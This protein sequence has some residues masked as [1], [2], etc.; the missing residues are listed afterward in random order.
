MAFVPQLG[1]SRQLARAQAA[2]MRLAAERGDQ[3]ARLIALE[4]GLALARIVSGMGPLL[5]WLTGTAIEGLILSELLNGL[6]LYPV[7]DD[8]WLVAADAII[9][10]ELIDLAPTPASLFTNKHLEHL[11][12]IQRSF[13]EGGR[14]VPQAH[15]NNHYAYDPSQAPGHLTPFGD[16]AWSNI[17]GRVYLSQGPV[18]AWFD[19]ART[20]A[21]EAATATGQ[22]ALTAEAEL[23]DHL[24]SADWRNPIGEAMLDYGQVVDIARR[25]QIQIAGTRVVLAIE[26]YRL[27]NDGCTPQSLDDLGDLLPEHLRS[28]PFTEQPWVYEPTPSTVG[29]NGRPLGD[30]EEA[31]PYTLRSRPMPNAPTTRSPPRDSP[32][33]GMLI[34]MPMYL[35]DYAVR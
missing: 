26:R 35:P 13:T 23:A 32:M 16:S 31:W 29:W 3:A 20:L 5:G 14:F 6:Y 1:E 30:D 27:R 7:D 25:P 19:K 12:E 28:D 24:S 17:H 18:E 8:A 9:V 15:V 10:R 21:I 22:A 33:N 4:E 2:R 34:T 11:D